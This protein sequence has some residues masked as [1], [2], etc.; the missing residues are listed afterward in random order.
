[1]MRATFILSFFFMMSTFQSNALEASEFIIK[2]K[3]L[4]RDTGKLVLFYSDYN[5]TG[6]V[7]TTYIKDGL[8]EFRGTINACT[9]AILFTAS[10]FREVDHPTNLN[11]YIEAG[12]LHL[13]I[14]LGKEQQFILQGS[15][16]QY[17]KQQWKKKNAELLQLRGTIFRESDSLRQLFK[18]KKDSSLLHL[19]N[20]KKEK[21][22]EI[23]N[24]LKQSD[25]I[26]INENPKSFYS[27]YLLQRYANVLSIDSLS[28]YFN[29]LH[30][31]VRKSGIGKDLEKRL[32]EKIVKD[33]NEQLLKSIENIYHFI[34]K[35]TSGLDVSLNTWKGK[36]LLIDFWASWCT[37]CIENIPKLKLLQEKYPSNTLQIVAVSFDEYEA[38][39]KQAI[40]RFLPPGTHLTTPYAFNSL[41]ALFYKVKSLPHYLLISKEGS[42]IMND[43]NKL[44]IKEIEMYLENLIRNE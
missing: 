41:I 38:S 27:G 1:M 37:P 11:F 26:Y 18:V 10:K 23:G 25:F 19:A 42:I 32:E 28:L 15:K 6:V 40:K 2:G 24:A 35:D 8:F 7:D 12:V 29:K 33:S 30:T 9:D 20:A 16:T 4:N 3:Y 14:T 17:E 31:K 43:I 44:G 13:E 39:W 5:G 21:L 22:L 36:Y 34:L